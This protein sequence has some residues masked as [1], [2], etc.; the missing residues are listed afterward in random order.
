MRGRACLSRR[1]FIGLAAAVAVAVAGPARP[2]IALQ[3][4]ERF[5]SRL[6]RDLMALARQPRGSRGR[7]KSILQ[8]H[9]DIRTV[10]LF[11]L[12]PYRR[13]L[14]QARRREYFALVLDYVAGLFAGYAAEFAGV[15]VE[16]TGSAPDGR[17]IIVNSAIVFAGGRRS[18]IR[19]RLRRARGGYVVSDINVSGVWL[20]LQ[21]RSQFTS[22]LG[23]HRGSFDALFAMLRG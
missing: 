16:I 14:P 10:A 6:T 7:F 3:P 4:H 20:S 18:P 23:R 12:G 17:F 11:A 9:S 2:A 5:V 15:D 19:W 1:R 8:R 13:S 22:T 21:L